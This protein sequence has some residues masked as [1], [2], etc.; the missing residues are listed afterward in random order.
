MR[1]QVSNQTIVQPTNSPQVPVRTRRRAQSVAVGSSSEV[2]AP[3][4][5]RR[6]SVFETNVSELVLSSHLLDQI[7]PCKKTSM[8]HHLVLVYS[9]RVALKNPVVQH[10]FLG[11]FSSLSLYLS[12]SSSSIVL[13]QLKT[14]T[15]ELHASVNFHKIK[16][17]FSSID[18]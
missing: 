11:F 5:Q 1:S 10:N 6:A 14:E 13:L 18:V 4:Q 12:R 17:C 3:Q 9:C 8:I 7:A 2:V 16:L 15:H